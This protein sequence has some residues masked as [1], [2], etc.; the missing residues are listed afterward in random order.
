MLCILNI[1]ESVRSDATLP[2]I[3]FR[4]TLVYSVV[5]IQQIPRIPNKGTAVKQLKKLIKFLTNF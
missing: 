4:K 1:H 2:C 3:E 5:G